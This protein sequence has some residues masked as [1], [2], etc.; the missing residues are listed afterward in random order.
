MSLITVETRN[1]YQSY[2]LYKN[3]IDRLHEKKMTMKQLS[4]ESGLSQPQ[5]W[6]VMRN[7]VRYKVAKI[8]H[9]IISS[10]AK[11]GVYKLLKE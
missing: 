5:V 2:L 11:A 1:S 4:M 7:L 8:S 6:L 3:I 10:G 9:Y